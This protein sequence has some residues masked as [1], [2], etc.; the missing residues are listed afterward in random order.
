MYIIYVYQFVKIIA[1]LSMEKKNFDGSGLGHSSS[2]WGR[3]V[4]WMLWNFVMLIGIGFQFCIVLVDQAE[5]N[6]TL[7]IFFSYCLSCYPLLLI[8]HLYLRV[9]WRYWSLKNSLNPIKENARLPT[10]YQGANKGKQ[11]SS[12]VWSYDQSNWPR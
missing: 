12:S 1:F 6:C 9:L 3:G 4:L 2:N 10:V 5:S 7:S 11:I 8:Y